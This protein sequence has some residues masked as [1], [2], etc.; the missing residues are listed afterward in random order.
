MTI[1][2][3]EYQHLIVEAE[4]DVELA[5]KKL[6]ECLLVF[7]VLDRERQRLEALAESPAPEREES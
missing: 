6:A 3:E 1:S 4:K 2:L 5:N 7:T